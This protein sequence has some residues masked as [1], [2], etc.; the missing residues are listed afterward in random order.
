MPKLNKEHYFFSN[1]SYICFLTTI[2][3]AI[4]DAQIPKYSSPYSKKRYNQHQLLALLLLKEY[5]KCGYRELIEMI[6]LMEILQ[7]QLMLKEIPHYSTLCKFSDRM[8][9]ETLNKLMKSLY[10]FFP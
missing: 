2:L 4:Q 3:N 7:K 10:R 1:Q 8:N 5:F 9:S 6:Q